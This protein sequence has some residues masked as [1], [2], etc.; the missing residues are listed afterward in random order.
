MPPN[1]REVLQVKKPIN[2]F[3]CALWAMAT[4]Y[5][6][7]VVPVTLRLGRYLADFGS[8]APHAT[9][10]GSLTFMWSSAHSALIGV[11]ELVGIG[12]LIELVDQIRW[13]GL[14]E[15]RRTTGRRV[16]WL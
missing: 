7:G 10:L 11:G 6:I 3:A 14:T 8:P 15:D 13:N 1:G 9:S 2:G 12:V 4:V 16:R 5:L